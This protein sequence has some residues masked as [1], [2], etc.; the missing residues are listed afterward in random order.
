MTAPGTRREQ[1]Q[2]T[3]RALLDA[4][5]G[6]LTDRG[7]AGLSLREV[8]KQA[9]VVPTAFY[10]HFAS[11]DELG[12]A[13]VEE[14]M[15]A[16]RTMMRDARGAPRG[17]TEIIRASVRTL[18]DDVHKHREHYWFLMRERYGGTGAVRQ[19]IAT[20]LRLLSG[21]LAVDLARF[22]QLRTWSTVDLQMLADLIVSAML[23][24]VLELLENTPAADDEIV[25]IA[26]K[27]LRLIALSIP[28]WRSEPV[29]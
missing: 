21:E 5:L 24:T 4:A 27:K 6:L 8:T 23:S 19:A 3:R 1:K 9:G 18:A 10:R 16:L 12:V 25:A 11:M 28:N 2:R 22:D 15:R 29:R 14:T 17:S 20:E 13:L 26:E 7:F